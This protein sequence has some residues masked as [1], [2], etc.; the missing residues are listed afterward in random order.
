MVTGKEREPFSG[1]FEEG[2]LLMCLTRARFCRI[3]VEEV[4]EQFTEARQWD[5]FMQ[6]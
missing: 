3:L 4:R 5:I 2:R 6:T 1:S